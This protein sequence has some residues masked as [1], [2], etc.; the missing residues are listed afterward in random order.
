MNRPFHYLQDPIGPNSQKSILP[1]LMK[2]GVAADLA[3][4]LGDG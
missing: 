3:T 4:V 2:S 1:K